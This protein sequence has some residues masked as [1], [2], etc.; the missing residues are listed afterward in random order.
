MEG[1]IPAGHSFVWMRNGYKEMRESNEAGLGLLGLMG[2][3]TYFYPMVASDF[4]CSPLC[5]G[6]GVLNCIMTV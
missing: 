2:G 6:H 3:S 4:S 1:K 5:E